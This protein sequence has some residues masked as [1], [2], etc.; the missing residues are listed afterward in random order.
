MLLMRSG[1]GRHARTPDTGRRVT[2]TRRAV[3]PSVDAALRRAC[4]LANVVDSVVGPGVRLL[5]GLAY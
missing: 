4:K 3:L 1:E 2:A 5:V